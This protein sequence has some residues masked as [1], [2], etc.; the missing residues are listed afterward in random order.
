MRKLIV[1]SFITLDSV[2]QAPGGPDED[3][4]GGF[5]YGG[6]VAGY[7]DDLLDRVMDEQMANPFELLLGRKT[8]EIFAAY[9][10][11]KDDPFA[12]KFNNARK[13]V[14]STTIEK[15]DWDNSTIIAGDVVG[16]IKKLKEQEGPEIQVHGSSNLIQTLLKNDLVD[17]L[18]LKIFPITIGTG[19]RLFASG[20][21]PASFRLLDSKT[22][23]TGV[24][25]A[26]YQRSGEI[27]TGA[28]D[29]AEPTEAELT[30]RK[31][32]VDSP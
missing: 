3:P 10:P 22:S 19:K 27:K 16:Q 25:I 5:K 28:I 6:W 1:L 12:D 14:V 24:I 20:T 23:T 31:R 2:M 9:W 26:T 13:Y 7:W 15:P 17:E 11:Y 8:Y 29:M 30:R 4:T 21:T 32:L 18:L